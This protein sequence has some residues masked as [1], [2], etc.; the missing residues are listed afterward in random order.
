VT[1]LIILLVLAAGMAVP[2]QSA[3]NNRLREAVDSPILSALVSFGIGVLALALLWAAGF[4]GRGR[5]SALLHVPAWNWTGGLCGALVVTAAIVA[6]PR[7]GTG[8]FIVFTILGQLAA[9]VLFDHFGWLGVPRSPATLPRI[10]GVVLVMV[11]AL[12]VVRK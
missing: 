9:S 5:P 1:Q 3:I 11:G 10:A 6:L 4:A 8:G 12:L 2:L 7:I